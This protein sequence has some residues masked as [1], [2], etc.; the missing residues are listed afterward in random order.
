MV[1][2]KGILKWIK[3]KQIRTNKGLPVEFRDHGFLL[4]YVRD[5]HNRIVVRKCTHPD[6]RVLRSDLKWVKIKNLNKGDS[7]V[8]ITES[9]PSGR[10]AR[11][12]FEDT[13][14]LDK[15][16]T[17]KRAFK[18][19]LEDGRSI[20][21]SEDHLFLAM[22]SKG[23]AGNQYDWHE[24]RN[25]DPGDYVRVVFDVWDGPNYE[26]GWIAG[27]LDGEGSLK[28]SRKSGGSDLV[29]SQRPGIVS[30]RIDRYLKSRKFKYH[31]RDD[32]KPDSNGPVRRFVL[33][34][35][36]EI[37]RLLGKTQPSRWI[38]KKFWLTMALGMAGP[39][40][41]MKIAS[42]E[43]AGRADLVDIETSNHTFIAEGI[44]THNCTQ[45][46]ASFSTNIKML[47][48]GDQAP[49]T[50]I[51]TLPT[52]SEAKNFVLT[53]FD[54]MVERSPG[55]LEMVQKV[56][57]REKILYNSVV[58][59]IGP[60]YYFFR[61]SWTTWGAQSIDADVLVVDELD[62]Q[63]EDVR[64]MWEERTEGSASQDI[65]YWIGYPSIPN[66]GIEEL[67]DSSDQRHWYI[68]CGHC[69]KRQ[70]LTF[71]ENIDFAKEI[72]QCKFCAGELTPEMRRR[73]IWKAHKPG[74]QIHGYWINKLMAPWITAPK[75]IHRFKNDTPKKFHNY[76]LGLPFQD[77]ETEI[78]DEVVE[79]SLMEE[80]KYMA[81][82]R[83]EKA[84][85]ILGID[86]G[87]IFH[88]LVAIAL[89]DRLVVVGA[90]EED[91]EDKLEKRI[92]FYNPD[93]VVMDMFPNRHTAK[94]MRRKIGENKFFMGKERNWSETSKQRN[95]W[96][97]NRSMGEIG[98]ERTESIDAMMEY[99]M[100]GAIR[101]RRSIPNLLSKDKHNPGVIQ[102]IRN[103]VP[104][105]QERFGKLRRVWKKT[106]PEHYA[107]SL[108]FLV[109]ACHTLFPGW[110][111]RE[112]IVPSSD[113]LAVPKPKPWYVKDF[114]RRTRSLSGND[115]VII[116]QG[117]DPVEPED[118][119]P[120]NPGDI[121]C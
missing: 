36:S 76:T 2:N 65:I 7:L 105:T 70:T 109:V 81:C 67:Y 97:T 99:I 6:T 62:F 83:D 79:R 49:L 31:V 50:T 48:L 121:Y 117:S 37:I 80:D 19:T 28:V 15:W 21:V 53:K 66:F 59:R 39:K 51:Y 101:F 75:I 44:V 32:D 91:S 87:D 77:K 118:I 11:R 63:R 14:V 33:S 55:L 114:E 94:K 34:R 22:K 8:G 45:V 110:Q 72:F 103:L 41:K 86:Q 35:T 115:T 9:A 1:S 4:D 112:M 88:I 18:M 93:M 52:S 90:H 23:R 100:K 74:R 113:L 95:Y 102:H 61:G 58:K 85:I 84:K 47:H 71:P 92:K 73:G 116:P 26:C 68:E 17:N 27:I 69:F 10:G 25:L 30:D 46:G 56:I 108:N 82:K 78:T 111:S 107:H 29:I 40:S 16:I 42:I 120:R 24:L 43:S 119:V 20:I 12:R 54:P 57:L 5:P 98:I 106:G 89:P 104:D 96:S 64:Q 3:Q 60:S 13:V 38:G